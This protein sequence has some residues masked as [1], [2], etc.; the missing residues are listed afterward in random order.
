VLAVARIADPAGPSRCVTQEM[1]AMGWLPTG[2]N[3]TSKPVNASGNSSMPLPIAI[4][5]AIALAVDQKEQKAAN[6]RRPVLGEE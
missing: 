1:S 4:A 3:S 5:I 6:S 2:S